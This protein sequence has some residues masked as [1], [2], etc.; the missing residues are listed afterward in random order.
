MRTPRQTHGLLIVAVKHHHGEMHFNPE[1]SY[2]LAAGDTLI[3]MG[4][5]ELIE[6][7]RGQYA[8]C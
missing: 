8:L 2:R 7:F 5:L 3:L 4:G 1:S 6:K